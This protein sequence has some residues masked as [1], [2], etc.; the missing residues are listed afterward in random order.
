MSTRWYHEHQLESARVALRTLR[1]DRDDL[2]ISQYQEWRA[3][4]LR[5]CTFHRQALEAEA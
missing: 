4:E 3:A 1:R 5:T 2:S